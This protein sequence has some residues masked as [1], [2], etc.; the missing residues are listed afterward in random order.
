MCDDGSSCA[1]D[2]AGF[3]YCMRKYELKVMKKVYEKKYTHEKRVNVL[4]NA[5]RIL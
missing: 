5:N 4:R 1:C 3:S 2:D